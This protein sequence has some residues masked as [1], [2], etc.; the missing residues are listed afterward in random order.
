MNKE[1]TLAYI[2]GAFDGDGSFSLIKSMHGAAKSPLY[3][4]LIQLANS[5]KKLTDLL[6]SELGG[7]VKTRDSYIGKDKSVRLPSHQWRVEK[8]IQCL[9]ILEQLIPY[10]TIKKHRAA[11]LRDYIIENPFIRGSNILS[12][13]VLM[14]R[15]RS[16]LKMR[17]FND[18]PD[19]SG[20][21]FSKQKRINSTDDIFWS[22][23]AGLMD[24]DGS[25]SLKRENRT[26]GGSKSPVYTPSILLTMVDCRAVYKIMNNFI[27]G[28]LI[29]VKAKTT[30][31]GFCYRFSI[32]S[33]KSAIDFLKKCIPFLLLKKEVASELLYFC[34]NTQR[35]NGIKQIP[36]DQILFRQKYYCRIKELNYGVSKS[37]LIDLKPVVVENQPATRGKI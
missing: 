22:Y 31:N 17:S 32:T 8:S 12:N 11:S 16:Y 20:E 29:I 27:G 4:P 2:A 1:I 30:T 19:N 10:L 21:L 37:S 24:T 36:E 3:F 23:V 18:F 9:P 5:N 14:R 13:S 35:L 6:E 15:E 26:S 25:F 33:R 7:S 28:N 34:E